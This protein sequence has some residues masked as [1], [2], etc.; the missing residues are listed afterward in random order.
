[1][2]MAGGWG[3]VCGWE[4]NHFL[5]VKKKAPYFS[6]LMKTVQ[7]NSKIALPSSI[8]LHFQH[9]KKLATQLVSDL[10]AAFAELIKESKWMDAE[11]KKEAAAKLKNMQSMV[12]YQDFI[13]NDTAL[14]NY[15]SGVTDCFIPKM[16]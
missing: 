2:M 8:S 5:T 1:M 3:K 11:T 6:D 14:D 16:L 7:E 15:Y 4:K 13:L 9:T 12:A 10:R